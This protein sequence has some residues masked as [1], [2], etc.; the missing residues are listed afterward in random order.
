MG[1]SNLGKITTSY[2]RIILF[3][4]KNASDAIYQCVHD[5]STRS[6]KYL[7]V[8]ENSGTPQIINFNRVF[9][10]KPSILGYLYFW[11]HLNLQMNGT[12][13]ELLGIG[14]FGDPGIGKSLKVYPNGPPSR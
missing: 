5:F 10:Y 6:L 7:D 12:M 8:S 11:K 13:D 3:R 4:K 1:R 9:H 2:Q 14:I